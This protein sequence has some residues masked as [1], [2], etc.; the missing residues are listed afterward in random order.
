M[1][2]IINTGMASMDSIYIMMLLYSIAVVVGYYTS[3]Q[4]YL[5][6]YLSLVF[7]QEVSGI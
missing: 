5:L 7:Y 1:S 2:V 3:Y 6:V 4:T